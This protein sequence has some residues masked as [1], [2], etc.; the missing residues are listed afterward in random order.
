MTRIIMIVFICL[1]LNNCAS[2]KYYKNNQLQKEQ[3]KQLIETKKS[4]LNI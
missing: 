1:L 3:Q 2:Y 4:W